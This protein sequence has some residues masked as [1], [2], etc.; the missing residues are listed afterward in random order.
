MTVL[1]CS[2]ESDIEDILAAIRQRAAAE[3]RAAVD[4][5]RSAD[6]RSRGVSDDPEEELPAVL[7]R[8]DAPP[9]ASVHPFKRPTSERLSEAF[10]R[11]TERVMRPG[12]AALDGGDTAVP[13]AAL[14][15]VAHKRDLVSFLDTRMRR[16]GVTD[17][18]RPEATGGRQLTPAIAAGAQL[19]P[20]VLAR[21]ASERSAVSTAEGLEKL[22]LSAVVTAEAAEILRPLL[23]AWLA[24]NMPRILER[25]LYMEMTGNVGHIGGDREA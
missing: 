6:D 9:G 21:V 4:E 19:E 18:P 13:D 1:P 23:K 15:P 12:V 25:A 7:R 10:R 8:A 22:D 16:M 17:E 5:H 2:D 3:T 11:A 14:T 20:V 24:E